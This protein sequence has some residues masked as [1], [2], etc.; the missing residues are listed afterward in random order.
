MAKTIRDNLEWAK[1]ALNHIDGGGRDAALLM[2]HVLQRDNSYVVAFDDVRLTAPQKQMFQAAVKRRAHYEPVSRIVGEREFWS[3]PFYVTPDTLDP[4]PETEV[5][6][7]TILELFPHGVSQFVDVGTGTGCIAISLLTEWSN[8]YALAVDVNAA[9]LRVAQRNAHRHDVGSR[10]ACVQMSF[11]AGL[12]GSV[13]LI[14]SNP[15]YIDRSENLD[16]DVAMYDPHMALFADHS[17]LAAYT[18]LLPQAFASLNQRGWLVLEIGWQ[19]ADAVRQIATSTGFVDV[20][21]K[22]DMAG[23]NRVVIAHKPD[24]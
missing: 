20:A 5:V 19:Q 8:A 23:H 2:A 17:G 21:V 12:S 7:E 15:P 9:A 10:L 13:D 3:L 16:P 11:I 18:E 24:R 6:I 14:A 1:S 22:R 4:R